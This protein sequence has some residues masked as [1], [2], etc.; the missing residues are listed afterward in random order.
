MDVKDIELAKTW[1]LN[2]QFVPSIDSPR[3]GAF[4]A[5]GISLM[6]E[7]LET[8]GYRL[9]PPKYSLD[10]KASAAYFDVDG[11]KIVIPGWYIL[12]DR[13]ETIAHTTE[14]LNI[15]SMILINGSTI[16]ESLH[17]AHTRRSMQIM[18]D[19]AK[20]YFGDTVAKYGVGLFANAINILE[21][22]RIESLLDK[23]SLKFWVNAKNNVLFND[24]E[25]GYVFENFNGTAETAISVAACY[26]REE[27]RSAV[28]DAFAKYPEAIAALSGALNS[29]DYDYDFDLLAKAAQFLTAFEAPESPSEAEDGNGDPFEG[30]SIQASA[31]GLDGPLSPKED[32]SVKAAASEFEK[33]S[34]KISK[35][36]AEKASRK[37][38]D[39]AVGPVESK[40]VTVV[41]VEDFARG[42]HFYEAN[43]R[44][45]GSDRFA[46]LLKQLRTEVVGHGRAK[47]IGAKVNATNLYRVATDGK[48]FSGKAGRKIGNEVEIIILVDAS[49]SMFS[50]CDV[51]Y[52]VEGSEA[53]LFSLC[54]AVAK[55]VFS[56]LKNA[57]IPCKVFAHTGDRETR[58]DP[59][60]I[61]VASH[62]MGNET[63]SNVDRKFNAMLRIPLNENYD[64]KILREILEG[65]YFSETA[66]KVLIVLSDGE[67]RGY[68]YRGVSAAAHT[69]VAVYDCRK[70]GISV[71]CLSLTKDVVH[72][73]NAIY[74]EAANIDASENVD[75]ALTQMVAAIAAGG[76]KI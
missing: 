55:K 60:L 57:D 22:V 17:R 47:K 48:V 46:Q 25:V 56:A 51:E 1:Y 66:K 37:E 68:D 49:G 3:F 20:R 30:A 19:D 9:T 43:V 71:V 35:E 73:N 34:R 62:R 26:K 69:K 8:E 59:V 41:D 16:H 12:K 33:A 72:A 27:L 5:K 23:A 10:A 75:K 15:V 74:G 45:R 70:A 76:R 6:L 32:Q 14:D 40:K 67:P 39:A 7:T 53:S 52:L 50:V 36:N 31:L 28:E 21:D 24:D 4:A 29:K 18:L 42:N 13:V 65:G 11:N 44:V 61:K 64:G 54:T 2:G 63:T 58:R 38:I